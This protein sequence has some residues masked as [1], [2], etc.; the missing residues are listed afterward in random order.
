MN[1]SSVQALSNA[2]AVGLYQATLGTGSP[3]A[4]ATSGVA[5]ASIPLPGSH[6]NVSQQTQPSSPSN[7]DPSSS[8]PV[9]VH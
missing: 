4:V 5:S 1:A 6:V 9:Y 2:L 3:S 8:E 7:V